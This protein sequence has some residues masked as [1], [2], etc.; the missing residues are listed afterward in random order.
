[1]AIN[2]KRL[3]S[4]KPKRSAIASHAQLTPTAMIA[5]TKAQATVDM[6]PSS[7]RRAVA[8]ISAQVASAFAAYGS[9]VR[10]AIK[11]DNSFRPAAMP[12][13]SDSA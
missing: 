3:R 7:A 11:P 5:L 2:Q 8:S 10:E 4:D 13:S 1:M 6:E 12:F 9:I